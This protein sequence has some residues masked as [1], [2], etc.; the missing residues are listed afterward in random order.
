MSLNTK[1]P[2]RIQLNG[3]NL[4]NNIIHLSWQHI[5]TSDGAADTDIKARLS[6]ARG[7]SINLKNIWKANDI[8]RKTKIGA[9]CLFCF[10]E[11]NAGE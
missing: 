5:V 4:S 6:K 7:A 11:Q 9:S 8:S 1:Q 10:T 3:K 2:A